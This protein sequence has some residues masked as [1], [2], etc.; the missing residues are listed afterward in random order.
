MR[1]KR[2]RLVLLLAA[3][4]GLGVATALVLTAFED[5]LVF[6]YSP[7]DLKTKAVAPDRRVRLGGLVEAGSVAREGTTVRF[8]VTDGAN[9][10]AVVY[11]GILPDLF[12]EGQGVVTEGALGADGAFRAASVLAK[13]DE[14]Y[15][16][17]DVAD[18]LKAA[19]YWQGARSKP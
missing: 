12:R 14:T 7:S 10:V 5:N 16:P 19:G 15:M 13:H 4:A 3:L 17:K 8:R 11:T 18:A 2:R 6:F 9:T 1:P